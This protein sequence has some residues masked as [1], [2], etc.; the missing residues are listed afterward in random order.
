MSE[1]LKTINE[2]IDVYE[3]TTGETLN[4]GTVRK[5][6]I[7]CGVGRVVPPKT[8]MLTFDEFVRVLETPL[9]M[10]KAVIGI[11]PSFKRIA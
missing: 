4:R 1:E 3:A 2:W 5:R 10:C 11:N 6:R 9:P 7:M 8:Y